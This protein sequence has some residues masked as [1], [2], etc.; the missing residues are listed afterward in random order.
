MKAIVPKQD[1]LSSD[2]LR[3]VFGE[4]RLGKRDIAIDLREQDSDGNG[5][6]TNEV[7]L[8]GQ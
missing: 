3:V 8:G 1:C 4:R 6:F 2:A 5:P 7:F